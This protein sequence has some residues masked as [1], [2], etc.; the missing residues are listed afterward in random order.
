MRVA[1]ATVGGIETRIFQAGSDGHPVLLVHGAGVSGASWL[2]NIDALG[3]QFQVCAPDT[4]GHGLTHPGPDRAGPPHPAMVAHLA[5][6]VDHLHWPKFHLVGSSFGALLAALLYFRMPERVDRLVVV[7]SGSFVNT[8]EELAQSLK[9]AY[10]NGLSAIVDP[11][12][13]NCRARMA[14]ICHDPAAVSD[15]MIF[16]QL[17]EYAMPWARQA[18]EQRLRGM[19]DIAACRPYRVLDRL[20]QFALPVLLLWGHNDTRGIYARA[21][22]ARRRMPDA[23]LIAFDRCKHHPHIEHAVKF[24]GIVARF[25]RSESLESYGD[26]V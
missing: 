9:E 14:R 8:D 21:Q 24:N 19:M 16:M 4:L 13:E 7:S 2:R 1:L 18:F 20:E 26:V 17:T 5:A 15:A 10:A 3:E 12:M 25:L 11:T 23:R 6:L 22:D